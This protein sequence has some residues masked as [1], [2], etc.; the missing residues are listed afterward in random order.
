MKKT[1]ILGLFLGFTIL[2][3]LCAGDPAK[4]AVTD[5]AL[6]DFICDG[7]GNKDISVSVD[8][9]KITIRRRGDGQSFARAYLDIPIEPN[10]K[11]IFSPDVEI[12]GAGAVTNFFLLSD[13]GGAWDEKNVIWNN[14]KES[15]SCRTVIKT[16]HDAKKMRISLSSK[17]SNTTVV[18][19]SAILYKVS[20]F[21]FNADWFP[22]D[23]AKWKPNS[24]KQNTNETE[25]YE[26][27]K[28]LGS[29]ELLMAGKPLRIEVSNGFFNIPGKVSVVEKCISID[30]EIKL[31]LEGYG[32]GPAESTITLE[33]TDHPFGSVIFSKADEEHL[34]SPE[35]FSLIIDNSG[36][37]I[38]GRTREGVL[39]GAATYIMMAR[40][41][42][43][44]SQPRLPNLFIADAP[45][46]VHREWMIGGGSVPELKRTIDAAYL[47]RLNKVE[48]AVGSFVGGDTYFPF[49]VTNIGRKQFTKSDWRSIFDYAKARGIEPTP[50][51]PSWGR[52]QYITHRPEYAQFAVPQAERQKSSADFQYRDYRNLDVANPEAVKLM[53]AIQGELI[54]ELKPSS[55]DI[56]FDELFFGDLVTSEKAK[57]LGW[58]PS[59]WVIKA[60]SLNAEFL[61]ERNTSMRVWGDMFDPGVNGGNLDICGPELL[62]KLPKDMVIYDW[63]YS[64]KPLFPSIKMFMDA[65]CKV[66][67]CSWTS[68]LN[69]AGIARSVNAYGA[70]GI[71]QTSWNNTDPEKMNPEMRRALSLM[72]YLSW[73]PEECD[74]AKFPF[75]PDIIFECA[76]RKQGPCLGQTRPVVVPVQCLSPEDAI[77]KEMNFPKNARLDFLLKKITDVKGGNIQPFSKD[78]RPAAAIVKGGSNDSLKIPINGNV[79]RL[80]FQH[81]VNSQ[82]GFPDD[83]DKAAKDKRL[84]AHA[85]SYRI[86]YSD[87]SSA[88]CKLI[89]RID[90]GDVNDSAIGRGMTPALFGT[91]NEKRF[92][93][94]PVFYWTNPSPEKVIESVEILP[95][96]MKNMDLL[97]FGVAVEEP[98]AK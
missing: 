42:A 66:V 12:S 36:V 74:L 94:M 88:E 58:K 25:R 46:M 63:K 89:F 11:Y 62:A 5:I 34:K 60:L 24:A 38:S 32:S 41:A 96:P 30:P 85:G 49:T 48:I 17:G 40:G 79:K 9:E 43:W 75:M 2:F 95:G 33:T 91:L 14:Y 18:Y 86:R 26:F 23:L 82:P 92:F 37:K 73:S 13:A 59:D 39:R 71:C 16:G 83:T 76:S 45:R 10:S 15:T 67:G 98:S 84:N 65:G 4:N 90:I 44:M 22:M 97:V 27:T 70:F 56:A 64:S 35:A 28:T 53:L 50:Y 8:N 7:R 68:P 51:L 78:G 80:L 31:M 72:A 6:K 52:V 21:D 61:K 29:P 87:G 57:A 93:N 1:I 3:S 81:S 20:C 19:K 55:I 69:I 77:L 54:D 47:L